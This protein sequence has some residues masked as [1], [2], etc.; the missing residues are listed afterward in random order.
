MKKLYP[1][2]LA[3][4]AAPLLALSAQFEELAFQPEDGLSLTTNS[5]RV[6]TLNLQDSGMTILFDGEE[7]EGIESPEIEL[8]MIETETLEFTDVYEVDEGETLSLRRTFVEIATLSEQELTDPEGEEF[9]EET[10]GASELEST[11]VIFTW[12]DD[13]DEFEAAFDDGDGDA[14]EEL[15]EGLVA[16]ADLSWFLPDDEIDEGDTWDVDVDAF[17]ELTSLSGDLVVVREDDDDEEDDFGEQF[18]ENLEGELVGEFTGVREEDDLRLAEIRLSGSLETIVE[19]EEEFEVEE[20]EGVK[21][22]T[23]DFDFEIEGLLLWNLDENRA[24]SLLLEGEVQMDV[25][26]KETVSGAGH[27]VEITTTQEFDGTVVY[28]VTIES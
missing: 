24:H 18:D 9:S 3:L 1:L 25:E 16:V 27:E 5:E 15:L 20:G 13:D 14:D 7:H 19:Q 21:V 10:P 26:S 23:Y 17:R 2:P 4:M 28:D 22:E 12:N 6:L 8:V 11:T